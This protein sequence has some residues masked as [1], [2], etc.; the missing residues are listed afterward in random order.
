MTEQT[1]LVYLN[2]KEASAFIAMREADF[3]NLKNKDAI[4]HFNSDK[5]ITD[6]KIPAVE[7]KNRFTFIYKRKKLLTN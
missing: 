7:K 4:V 6:I 1:T 3:F 5:V 2:E